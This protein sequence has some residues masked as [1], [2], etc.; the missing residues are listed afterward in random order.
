MSVL[1]AAPPG[2]STI[3]RSPSSIRAIAAV[4]V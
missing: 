3:Q 1:I 2:P 4:S